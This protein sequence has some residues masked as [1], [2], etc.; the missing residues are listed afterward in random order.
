[1]E[2][3]E[4]VRWLLCLCVLEAVSGQ[5]MRFMNRQH[6]HNLNDVQCSNLACRL[7][8]R[9][10]CQADTQKCGSCLEGYVEE[11]GLC[12]QDGYDE[13]QAEARAA[14][15]AIPKLLFGKLYTNSTIVITSAMACLLRAMFLV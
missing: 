6:Y 4:A 5:M 2:M 15:Q 14:R 11:R 1:M 7:A 9:G 12:K 8:R 13:L 3:K 10:E